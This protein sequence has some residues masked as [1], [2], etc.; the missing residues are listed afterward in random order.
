MNS[1]SITLVVS[2]KGFISF[3]TQDIYLAA[4]GNFLTVDVAYMPDFARGFL[5][6]LTDEECILSTCTI[7]TRAHSVILIPR[8]AEH[9]A[10]YSIEF[11]KKEL[12][13]II[14]TWEQITCAL[15]KPFF[16]KKIFFK[17]VRYLV[18]AAQSPAHPMEP[19]N[20]PRTIIS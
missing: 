16:G 20:I 19:K 14:E 13:M 12:M 11:S 18:H 10:D 15:E 3:T 6:S 4:L 5:C 9:P 7:K 2:N 1:E 17:E 8:N